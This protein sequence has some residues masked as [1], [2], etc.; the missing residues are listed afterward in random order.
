MQ[1]EG[2]E[3]KPIKCE[4]MAFLVT[5]RCMVSVDRKLITIK[6]GVNVWSGYSMRNIES[7]EM[8]LVSGSIR[9]KGSWR[10]YSISWMEKL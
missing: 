7:F 5:I 9:K 10:T 6:Q 2:I 3:K 1:T 4:T 8:I